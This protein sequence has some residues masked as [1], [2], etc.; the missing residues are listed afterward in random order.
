MGARAVELRLC[1]FVLV[2]NRKRKRQKWRGHV[3]TVGT[4]ELGDGLDEALVQVGRPPQPRLGVP[5]QHHPA[6]RC[7]AAVSRP[8]HSLEH[9]RSPLSI[10]FLA[11]ILRS[12]LPA[13]LLDRGAAGSPRSTD[14]QYACTAPTLEAAPA[15]RGGDWRGLRR[16][17]AKPEADSR[18][19]GMYATSGA[20]ESWVR[21]KDRDGRRDCEKEREREEY[22]DSERK[23]ESEERRASAS[24]HRLAI[25]ISFT[26][27]PTLMCARN[28]WEPCAGGQ[29]RPEPTNTQPWRAAWP[30][31]ALPGVVGTAPPRP[32]DRAVR[33][34]DRRSR[35][36][37]RDL[38]RSSEITRDRAGQGACA[39]ARHVEEAGPRQETGMACV[40]CCAVSSGRRLEKLSDRC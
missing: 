25:I 13:G 9:A 10:G 19:E 21:R 3:L 33:G 38:L 30:P 24:E 11:P 40:R 6:H 39:A 29:A 18:R 2:L 22:V 27:Y 15:R 37:I 17:S 28:L 31:P 8:L 34:I 26:T 32:S 14:S 1:L 16:I 12:R 4:A 23:K 36:W 20:F 7:R 35:R 5:R